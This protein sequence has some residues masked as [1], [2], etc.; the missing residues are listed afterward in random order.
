[1]KRGFCW[2][3]GVAII[4]ALAVP[5]GFCFAWNGAHGPYFNGQTRY[6]W[7][8]TWHAQNSVIQP[9]TPY[10]IPRTPGYCGS[11]SKYGASEFAAAPL[12]GFE[13]LQFERLGQ[14]PNELDVLGNLNGP[15]PATAGAPR[16]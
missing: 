16:R 7:S 8:R 1:M 9:V 5:S 14:V 12:V 6:L 13:P 3:I 11:G 4:A 10:Y 2:T 15:P